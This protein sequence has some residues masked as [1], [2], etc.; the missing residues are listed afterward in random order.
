MIIRFYRILLGYLRVR[1]EGD[2]KERI[3]SVCAQNGITLWATRLKDQKIESNISVRD[4][5]VLRRVASGKGVRVHIVKKRGIPFIT[6]RYKKRYGILAGVILFFFLLGFMSEFIWIIDVNGNRKISGKQILSACQ[7]IGITQGIKKNSIYPKAE[8]EKLMLKLEGI[9]WASLNIEGSRLTVNVTET[10]EKDNQTQKFNNL[11]AGAD[12]IIKKLDIVSG[13]SVVSVGQAVKK[14]D[15]L[16]SG[17]VETADG[18]R[19]TK[20]KGE[21]LAVSQNEIV[22]YEEYEQKPLIP[23]G[24]VKVKRI[25]EI[26]GLKIPLYLGEEKGLF[27]TNEKQ[28]NLQL[29]GCALPIKIYSKTFSFQKQ[30]KISFDY[31]KLCQRLENK[32]KDELADSEIEKVIKKDFSNDEKGVT[33]RVIIEKE[34]NIAVSD[35]LLIN[36]GN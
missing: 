33:L 30:E 11:K 31:E 8:R 28:K 13:T 9:A 29:F 5:R 7:S 36:A 32:L 3:L 12:G 18:T 21:V 20:A 14:G 26:F 34:E 19:F 4:F 17:I 15:L 23:I 25:I 22:L 10:K 6:N 27:E 16:V 24:K 2:F 35:I 1:F